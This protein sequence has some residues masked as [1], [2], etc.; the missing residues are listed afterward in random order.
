MFYFPPIDSLHKTIAFYAWNSANPVHTAAYG[1]LILN[2]AETNIGNAYNT[3]TGLFT[4]PVSGLYYFQT[5][6]LSYR[7][8]SGQQVHTAI[9]VGSNIMAEGIS[10]TN[11]GHYDQTTIN[12]IVHVDAGDEVYVKNM[13]SAARD[14]FDS[15]T[16][17]RTTFSGFLINA[18]L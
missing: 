14:Y 4:A 2:H 1:T 7:L 6:F 17:Q 15:M 3:R 13:E 5:T 16:D 9:Y 11:H 10:D 12:T 18:D 8:G